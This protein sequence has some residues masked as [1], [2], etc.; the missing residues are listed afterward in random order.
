VCQHS[1]DRNPKE[2]R[3]FAT[4]SDDQLVQSLEDHDAPR[5]SSLYVIVDDADA[6][7]TCTVA[8]GA[9]IIMELEDADYGGRGYTCRDIEGNGW[10]FGTYDPYEENEESRARISI[11][12]AAHSVRPGT[13]HTYPR[14][15]A[16]RQSAWYRRLKVLR[17]HIARRQT[18]RRTLAVPPRQARQVAHSSANG[19]SGS[20]VCYTAR[21]PGTKNSRS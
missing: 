12:I 4:Q 13:G 7:Y 19:L 11:G 18:A 20:G 14:S 6:H 1:A 15:G 16:I 10:T 9:E 8:A 21:L 2:N 3:R 5:P 17:E